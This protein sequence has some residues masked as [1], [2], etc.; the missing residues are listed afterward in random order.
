[1]RTLPIT[2]NWLVVAASIV[3]TPHVL[4]APNQS[5]PLVEI[6]IEMERLNAEVR[7]LRNQVETQTNELDKLKNSQQRLI[8]SL[9]QRISRLEGGTTPSPASNNP[10]RTT[11]STAPRPTAGQSNK[12]NSAQEQAAYD[13]AFSLMKQGQYGKAAQSFE[14]FANQYPN[15]GLAG[16]ARYWTGQAKYVVRDFQGALSEFNKLLKQYPS[17]SKI[18]DTLLKI[19]YC[20]DEL[21]Q[22]EQAVRVLEEVITRFPN[23]PVSRL[24]NDRLA[25]IKKSAK[26]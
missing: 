18:E 21:G 11:N 8:E 6:A 2:T 13:K 3:L 19:G 9:D 1:M 24:A 17:S 12:A 15:S 23:T 4:A 14:A 16:N 10:P 5:A 26:R 20:H 22:K 25:K 7:A